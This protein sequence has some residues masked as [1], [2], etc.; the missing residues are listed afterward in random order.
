MS[1]VEPIARKLIGRLAPSPTGAQHL[2]NAR[3]FLVAWLYIRSHGGQLILR[4]EDL[5]TPRTKSWANQ[6][7][8]DDLHWLGIDWDA[9]APLQSTRT[10]RYW[11]TLEQLKQQQR[12]YPCTCTRTQVEACSSA[13]HESNLDGVVYG[14]RCADRSVE[15]AERLDAQ[16]QKYAWRFRFSSGLME[17]TDDFLGPQRLDAKRYL[18]DFIVARNYGPPA[19]QLAVTVDDHAQEVSHVLRGDDLVFSTYRQ[20][21][22]YDALGWSPPGW[23]HVP[24]VVGPDGKRLAKRHGDTRLSVWREQGIR[25]EEILG[26]IARSLSLTQDAR[27]ISIRE[28][29]EIARRV[30]EWWKQI[31]K[32]PTVLASEQESAWSK[33]P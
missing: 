3:T 24:L 32:E 6:Q 21:A 8:I 18:G 33:R 10:E 2:G 11:E 16:G 1:Q 12:V 31:P 4:I 13:P 26:W 23:L 28:L 20:I 19:Y 7:A 29:L 5:D 22:I 30:P 17:W 25:A 14:G 27:P 9:E 15:D